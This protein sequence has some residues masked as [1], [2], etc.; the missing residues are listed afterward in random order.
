MDCELEEK[1]DV[2]FLIIKGYQSDHTYIRL[3]ETIRAFG[4]KT[5][6]PIIVKM[7]LKRGDFFTNDYIKIT[8]K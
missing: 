5:N 2:K 1:N 8:K 4:L 3:L 7:V 6:E